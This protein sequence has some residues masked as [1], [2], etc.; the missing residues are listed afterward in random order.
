MAEIVLYFCTGNN[1]VSRLIR[2]AELG[3]PYSHVGAF[4]DDTNV[5]SAHWNDGVRFRLIT[6]ESPWLNW[7]W[8]K[9]PCTDEQAKNHHRWLRGEVG[10]PYDKVA[11]FGLAASMALAHK[12]AD[13]YPDK[14]ICSTLQYQALAE[15]GLMP[16]I[17]PAPLRSITPEILMWSCLAI[18]GARMEIR[19][20]D[21]GSGK[22]KP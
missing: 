1:P 3:F 10:K 16:T 9:I 22:Q 19:L 5:I 17:K 7:A 13:G 2:R 12:T 18:P 15:V 20:P 14:W 4:L 11:I 21:N 8:V 6:D